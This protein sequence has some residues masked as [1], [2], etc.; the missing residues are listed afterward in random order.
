MVAYQTFASSYLSLFINPDFIENFLKSTQSGF[1]H[2][3]SGTEL[4]VL[5]KHLEASLCICVVELTFFCYFRMVLKSIYQ[6]R[7]YALPKEERLETLPDEFFGWILP[8]LRHRIEYYLPMG[9][10]AYFFLRFISVLLVFFASCGTLN[11]IILVPLNYSGSSSTHSAVGMDRL[12]I[13]NISP[14]KSCRLNAHWVCGLVTIFTI[15]ALTIYELESVVKIRHTYMRS[16]A[17]RNRLWSRVLLLGHVPQHLK[18]KEAI[19]LFVGNL[20]GKVEQVW[21]VDD[22]ASFWWKRCEAENALDLL[23][24]AKVK[25]LKALVRTNGKTDREP[26]SG[27]NKV[28]IPR[29]LPLLSL[30]VFQRVI[31]IKLPGLLRPVRILELGRI[32]DWAFQI[33]A[34]FNQ[35][36]ENRRQVLDQFSFEKKGQLFILFQTQEAANIVHQVVLSL[37]VWQLDQSRTDVNPED[38]LWW[39]ISREDSL[40]TSLQ[41]CAINFIFVVLCILYMVP[42]SL[43]TIMSQVPTLVRLVPFLGW[44]K[45]LPQNVRDIFSS[46][47]PSLLLS[48]LTESVN[49]LTRKLTYWKG[50]WTGS[51]VELNLQQWYFGFLFTQQ[52]LVVS[53]LSSL[54]A[55][56]LQI[57]NEPASIP[58][59]FATNIPQSATFFF[60]FLPVQAFAVCG[61]CFLQVE[62]LVLQVLLYLWWDVTP[63]EKQRRIR[64]LVKVK[65]GSIYPSISVF[66]SIGVTYCII[67]P[68][69]SLFMIVNFSLILVSYKYSLRYIFDYSNPSETYGRLYPK[70]L[71][72]LYSGIYCLELYLIGA[73]LSQQNQSGQYPMKYHGLFMV[74][75]FLTTIMGNIFIYHRYSRLISNMAPFPEGDGSI[76]EARD[77]Q[78]VRVGLAYHHPCYQYEQPE[79]WLPADEFGVAEQ[80]L[81]ELVAVGRAKAAVRGGTTRGAKL[82]NRKHWVATK[83][84]GVFEQ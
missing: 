36:I 3:S 77:L 9:L 60:K 63:R 5:L 41:S 84:Q 80:M 47:L 28:F 72:Q 79:L 20:P 2:Q 81:E 15:S 32:E 35:L 53:I 82:V 54:C 61:G 18:S 7:S 76:Q 43:I 56:M 27:N 40:L 71:F 45:N 50:F 42:V 13:T 52:F 14:E 10:D 74:F 59:L 30:P 37:E 11:L 26:S 75:V 78:N 44:L 64:D 6:P 69:I 22:F 62:R 65:W 70:A 58:T 1:A 19:L 21:F 66:G 68:L 12:S 48:A 25:E 67:S 39:N 24:E 8:T 49:R 23:E 51:E 73:C 38:I 34:N 55:V 29:Y 31:A 17:H 57:V 46:I 4:S 16:D 83:M 33:L